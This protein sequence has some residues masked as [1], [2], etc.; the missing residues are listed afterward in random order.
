MCVLQRLRHLFCKG[1]N[2]RQRNPTSLRERVAQRPVRRIVHDQVGDRVLHAKIEDAHNMGM[3]QA[4]N[5]LSLAFEGKH[6]FI[7]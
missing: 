2:G 4:R 5:R 1:D 7:R 6:I 3:Q